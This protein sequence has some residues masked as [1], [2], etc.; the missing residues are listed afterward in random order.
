MSKNTS[1]DPLKAWRDWFVQNERDWSESLTKV[2]KT[3]AVSRAVG[4]EINNSLYG[5]QMLTQGMAGSLAMLNLPTR[6]DFVALSERIGRLEDGVARIEAALVQARNASPQAV[7]A[8][9]ARTRKPPRPAKA[10][11]P[12]GGAKT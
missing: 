5:Q 12:A 6:E 11:A 9:P 10:G 4:Q 2:M 1:T 7:A 8:R 3:E